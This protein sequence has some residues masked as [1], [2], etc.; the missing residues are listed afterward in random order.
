MSPLSALMAALLMPGCAPEPPTVPGLFVLGVDGMDPVIL[1]RLMD[2]GKLPNLKALA[3]RGSFQPLGTVNPPQSPVAWSSFVTGL[4][5][6]G[7]GIFDFVHR[8][9]LKYVPISSA[10]PPPGD[11]GSA[12]ELGGYYFPIGGDVVGN[13]RGGTPFWDSLHDIGVDVEV[14]RIP[15][16]YPVTESKAKVLAGMGTV[17][18]RGGYGVY[19]WFTD[20]PVKDREHVKGDIQLVTVDDTDLDGVPDTV[21]GTV[22]G[23]PDIFHL[24]P[25]KIPEDNDYLTA[26]VSF[27][28]DPD[29]DALV[30]RAGDD[31]AVIKE[32]EFSPWMKL[33]FDALPAGAMPFE[34]IVR[35]YAKE[36]RPGFVVYAS[37]VNISPASPAQPI[38]TPDAFATDLG[39]ILGPFYTQGMPEETNAL[40]DGLFSDD[41]YSKQ[42]ALVQADTRD[43][44]DVALAR[45]ESGDMTFVYVSDVDLQCHMLWRHGD[46]KHAGSAPHPAFEAVSAEKHRLD[47]E[48]YYVA[49]DHHVQ[50]IVAEMPEDS[51]LVVM[52]DHGFQPYT[53]EV[54]LNTWLRDNGWLTLKD[55]KTTG[56]IAAGEVDWSKTRAYGIGF[57]AVYL[58]LQGREAEGTVQ[59]AEADKVMAELSAQLLAMTDP[60]NAKR[61]ILRVARSKDIYAETR[62]SE[63][64]DLVIGYDVGYGASDQSTLGEIVELWIE[65]N[66]SRWSGN[67]LMAPEVVPGV[68]LTNRPVKASGYDLLDVTSTVLSHYNLP[69]G[70]GQSGES[71]FSP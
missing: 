69:N 46:P 54:H 23:P 31:V 22:K 67:H 59:A 29:S 4:D 63:A 36:V 3:D 70:P 53:R 10:T 9:P 18:M 41:D 42:V 16:N 45:F 15:G 17:D 65:D 62:R 34:A 32:G 61:P 64:P 21:N 60:S 5:P 8:D 71:V 1:Q 24:P 11:L 14:Y 7:H 49:V 38:S 50:R 43:M 56:Q 28:L 2:E 20:Q 47:I 13:N 55:G 66:T 57:N 51:T 58:N 48:R 12:I 30:V 6:G 68:L 33:S 39:D 26:G 37:P 25:G 40:K 27:H 19:T 44:L 35:F 52:S